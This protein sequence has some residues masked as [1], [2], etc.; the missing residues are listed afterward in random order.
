MCIR[1]NAFLVFAMLSAE[2]QELS[3]P[4]PLFLDSAPL[5]VRI[6]LP[7][8][9]LLEERPDDEEL[10]GTF[11]WTD[12][13]GIERSA[14]VAVRTRGNYRREW[15]T[16][17]FPPLRLNFRKSEV[18]D[19]V[20]SGQDKVKLVTHCRPWSRLYRES[21]LR[22]YMAYR[23]LNE[24]TDLSFRVRLLQI[25]YENTD[26]DGNAE[27][28]FGFLIESDDRLAARTGLKKIGIPSTTVESLN[29]GFTNLVSLFQYM[30]ANTD[31]SPIAGPPDG[32]CCHNIE[33]FEDDQGAQ[34]PIPY[35]FDMSGI[36]DAKYASPN[37]KLGIRSVKQR[38]YRGRCE[39]NDQIGDTVALFAERKSRIYDTIESLPALD[40]RDKRTARRFI[41]DFFK[42]IEDPKD[43]DRE[44]VRNCLP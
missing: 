5:G 19:T 43:L 33:L 39:H 7:I 28:T 1:L 42:T 14:Y 37:P 18:E 4:D 3:Q 32:D 35:D 40:D 36:V 13:D 16:C 25:T 21:M 30:I 27:Q 6:A 20:L 12:A 2:A 9:R 8:E 24:L 17:P 41:D 23:M 44:L 15:R 11:T 34:F 10:P 26:D 31:F 38:L 22:E 29:P